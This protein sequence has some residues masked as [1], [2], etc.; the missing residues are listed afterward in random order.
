MKVVLNSW[1]PPPW[2]GVWS[3]FHHNHGGG[4]FY[5]IVKINATGSR[6]VKLLTTYS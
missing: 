3:Y 5:L 4:F 2:V 1:Y 6:I